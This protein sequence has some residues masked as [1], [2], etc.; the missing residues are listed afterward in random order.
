MFIIY[1]YIFLYEKFF[2]GEKNEND[3]NN[4]IYVYIWHKWCMR[5]NWSLIFIYL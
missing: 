2:T 3:K 1:L 4:K 5:G